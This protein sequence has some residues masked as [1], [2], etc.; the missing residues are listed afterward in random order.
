MNPTFNQTGFG[1]PN[2]NNMNQMNNMNLNMNPMNNMPMLN[3][4]NISLFNKL[5]LKFI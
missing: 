5:Y 3:N 4:T 2:M 1:F